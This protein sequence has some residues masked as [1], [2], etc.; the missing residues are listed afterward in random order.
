VD[1]AKQLVEYHQLIEHGEIDS[2]RAGKLRRELGQHFGQASEEMQLAD[3][4]VARWKATR[5]AQ[6]GNA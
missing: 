3:L 5:K 2:E 1:M 6:G 4:V